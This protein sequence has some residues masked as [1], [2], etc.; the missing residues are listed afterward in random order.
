MATTLEHAVGYPPEGELILGSSTAMQSLNATVQEIARTNIPVLL[1]GESGTGKE[2]YARLIHRLSPFS[3]RAVHKVNCAGIEMGRRLRD[4]KEFLLQRG[5]KS[6]PSGTLFLDGIEDLDLGSQRAL[7]SLLSDHESSERAG[8]PMARLISST[9]RPLDSEIEAGQFR[10]ELYFRLSG[11]I[12]RLPPLRERKQDIQPLLE[13]FLAKHAG[14]LNKQLPTF[15]EEALE[16]FGSYRWPGNIREL[17]HIAKRS[18]AL[19]DCKAVLSE[20]RGNSWEPLRGEQTRSF[21]PLKI[22]ARAALRKTEKE[23]ILSA[24]QRTRWNRKRAAMDLRISYKSLLCK[25]KQI[26]V[27][28]SESQD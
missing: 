25:I 10:R 8:R 1:I 4:V 9:S 26:G 24:L 15:S 6:A 7:V 5:D 11:A 28:E 23:L 19:G 27:Q 21:S 17:E 13:F 3:S 20:I 16:L 14:E 18:V 12:L 2:V 22:A